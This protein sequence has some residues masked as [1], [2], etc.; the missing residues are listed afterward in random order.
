MALALEFAPE[1]H[2]RLEKQWTRATVAVARA[3]RRYQDLQ[4]HAHPDERIE[5]RAWLRLWKAEQRKREVLAA[6]D[7][8]EG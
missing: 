3:Q 6:L 1:L 8:L 2:V 4:Y 7:A 5:A